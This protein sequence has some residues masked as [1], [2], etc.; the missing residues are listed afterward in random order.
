M[1]NRI[2]KDSICTSESIEAIGSWEIEVFWYRLLVQCDDYGR[3]DARPAILRARC[4][5]LAMDRVSEADV[6]AWLQNLEA[7][8]LIDIYIVDGKPYLRVST[9]EKH[10]Q[11]RAKHSKYPP[12]P[13]LDSNG[14]HTQSDACYSLRESES[15]SEEEDE[16]DAALNA[17]QVLGLFNKPMLDQFNDMWP[18]LAGRRDWLGKS[19]TIARDNGAN[20]PAYA[21]K[22]LA[23]SIHTGKEPGYTNGKVKD[24]DPTIR[25]GA[26]SEF[27]PEQIAEADRRQA[28]Y[29]AEVAAE[30]ARATRAKR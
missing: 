3:M 2:L 1:P 10:Q 29:E 6:T 5:P 16:K 18:E 24:K 25:K 26:P 8:G 12:P 22:V 11:V 17:L 27:T 15:E 23:N 21:L 30:L 14:N 9:W 20:S 19:I 28:A 4:Y 7:V 13:A